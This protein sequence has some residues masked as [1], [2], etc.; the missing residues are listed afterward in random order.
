MKYRVF[1]AT[2]AVTVAMLDDGAPDIE[3]LKDALADCIQ[4][5]I[6]IEAPF[7]ADLGDDGEFPVVAATIDWETLTPSEITF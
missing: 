3:T 4:V 2:V 5:D 1:T 6:D 7:A